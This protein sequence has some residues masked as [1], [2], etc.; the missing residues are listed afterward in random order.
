MLGS[1]NNC[2]I[3]QISHTAKSCEEIDKINQFVID[4][5]SDYMSSLVKTGKYGA[6]NK[7][8]TTTMGYYVIKF[9]SEAYT[10]QEENVRRKNWFSWLNS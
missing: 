1:F 7:T 3:I 5:I 4:G 9:I 6:L 2:N 10:L 8:G